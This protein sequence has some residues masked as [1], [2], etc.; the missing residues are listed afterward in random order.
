MPIYSCCSGSN[1][2]A[3]ILF[4]PEFNQALNKLDKIIEGQK[5]TFESYSQWLHNNFGFVH[6]ASECSFYVTDP[7]KFMMFKIKYGF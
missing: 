2:A 7:K 1:M 4:T 3:R 5:M 6:K